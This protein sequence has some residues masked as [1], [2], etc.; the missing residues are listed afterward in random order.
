MLGLYNMIHLLLNNILSDFLPLVQT[1]VHCGKLITCLYLFIICRPSS[2]G[3]A[4]AASVL[5]GQES[6]GSTREQI[7]A[8]CCR[9][10]ANGTA[11]TEVATG[12][13]EIEDII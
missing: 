2:D 11:Y 9:Q 13:V 8:V 7:T 1:K 5:T 10:L 6:S 4:L 12:R 3:S